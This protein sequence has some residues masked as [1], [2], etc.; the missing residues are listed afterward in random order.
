MSMY[1]FRKKPVVIE[2]F[3]MTVER[4]K[5]NRLWPEW[6]NAAWNKDPSEP[7][8]VR[9]ENYPASDGT[10]NLVIQTL[11]GKMRVEW[12]DW[13]IQGVHGEIYPCKP[14]IFEATYE[15]A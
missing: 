5:D 10:E 12:S 11:E 9:P 8:S 2:A 13:I 4:R 15:K 3:Q 7:G 6:L 14:E 1:E